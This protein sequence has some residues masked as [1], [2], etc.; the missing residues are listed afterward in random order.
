MIE[1]LNNVKI[2]KIIELEK[3]LEIRERD[4]GEIRQRIGSK[5][6]VERQK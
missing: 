2:E 3:E 6:D 1:R 5:D 4:K